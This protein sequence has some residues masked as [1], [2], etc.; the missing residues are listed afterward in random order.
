MRH[1]KVVLVAAGFA[2]AGCTG[3]A[4]ASGGPPPL[5]PPDP[6]PYTIVA[7]GP[8]TATVHKPRRRTDATVDR[9]VRAARARAMP[10]AIAAARR[11]A[12]GLGAAAGLMP[13]AVVA[14][15]RDT[16]PPGWWSQDDGRF[17]PSKWCGRIYTGRR[18]VR[19][20]DGTTRRVAR[21]RHG[22]QV[23]KDVSIRLSVTFAATPR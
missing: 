7:S 21:Y 22:C 19:R 10:G 15:R 9:A 4:I 18:T 12:A 23:P 3:V 17:G 1:A 11:E 20:A 16:S 5:T 6:P 8:G 2:A 13:G 14:V